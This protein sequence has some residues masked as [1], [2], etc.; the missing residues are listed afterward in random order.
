MKPARTKPLSLQ[1]GVMLLEALLGILIFTIGILGLMGMQA[2]ATRV[3]A[4]AKYR[5][6][7]GLYA[8]QIVNQMW[9]D[10]KATLATDYATG[11]TKYQA[12]YAE[13]T[14]AGTGLPG[15][16]L[17]ANAPTVTVAA[18]NVVTV[19]IRWQAPGE[20]AAHRYVVIAQIN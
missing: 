16:E 6:E 7:A 10:N 20:S 15:A 14:A 1:S 8:D 13:M 4:D 2:A 5:S 11:G 3:A 17:S 9:A 12:W 19:T 18:G